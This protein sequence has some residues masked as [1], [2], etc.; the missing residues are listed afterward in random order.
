MIPKIG[1]LYP[2]G[3][4]GDGPMAG[5]GSPQGVSKKKNKKEALSVI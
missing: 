2:S 4:T 1:T 5:G 3:Y